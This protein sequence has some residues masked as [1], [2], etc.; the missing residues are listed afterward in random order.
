MSGCRVPTHP[1][2]LSLSFKPY[3]RLISV[4]IPVL[5][6]LALVVKSQLDRSVALAS[7]SS[8]CLFVHLSL[9]LSFFPSIS[10]LGLSFLFFCACSKSRLHWPD[11][12]RACWQRSYFFR[13]LKSI[14]K[15]KIRLANKSPESI[16]CIWGATTSPCAAVSCEL[17]LC[18]AVWL[19][20]VLSA[21]H[22]QKTCVVRG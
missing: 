3:F 8:C 17:M 16:F 5:L 13:A 22:D 9:F 1:E 4:V 11:N 12:D 18:F 19:V 21:Q 2:F 14:I 10:L 15:K 7:S 6:C 20:S